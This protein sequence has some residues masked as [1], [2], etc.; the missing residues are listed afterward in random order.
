MLLRYII[1]YYNEDTCQSALQFDGAKNG[2]CVPTAQGDSVKYDFPNASLYSGVTD[3]SGTPSVT[4]PLGVP[5]QCVATS[6]QNTGNALDFPYYTLTLNN[7]MS[8]M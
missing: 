3:C 6:D 8:T 1:R 5:N 4:G 7:T 2:A